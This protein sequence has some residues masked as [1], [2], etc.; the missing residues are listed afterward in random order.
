MVR[1]NT[2]KI[3]FAYAIPLGLGIIPSPILTKKLKEASKTEER[4]EGSSNY[5]EAAAMLFG[6]RWCLNND[7]RLVWGET[8]YLLLTNC[9]KKVWKTPWKIASI[10]EDIQ[11]LVE[12]SES[13]ITHC[14]R[15]ANK[16][17][18]KLAS[19]SHRSSE[20]QIFNSFSVLPVEVKGLTNVDRWGIP[21]LRTKDVPDNHIVYDPP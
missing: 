21:S 2:G 7:P 12:D 19:L 17:A 6:L 15:E 8:D 1:D 11:E 9:I 14:F 16:P 5:A 13:H 18:D 3:I 4:E 20:I 10:V